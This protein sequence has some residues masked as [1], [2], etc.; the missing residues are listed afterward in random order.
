M[1]RSSGSISP[2]SPLGTALVSKNK[3][4]TDRSKKIKKNENLKNEIHKMQVS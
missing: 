3:N 4:L 1:Y 2:G